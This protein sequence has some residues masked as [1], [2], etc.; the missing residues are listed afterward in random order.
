MVRSIA[1]QNCPMAKVAGIVVVRPA[2]DPKVLASDV[3]ASRQK[4]RDQLAR[5][6]FIRQVRA[7]IGR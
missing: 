6:R 5:V 1:R 4:T 2:V 7:T 3:E